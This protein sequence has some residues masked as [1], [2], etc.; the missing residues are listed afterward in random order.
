VF[1]GDYPKKVPK[2]LFVRYF[3]LSE[4]N[5]LILIH[6]SAQNKCYFNTVE[7]FC[8]ENMRNWKKSGHEKCL[9]LVP[10]NLMLLLTINN[11]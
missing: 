4:I 5:H 6:K 8:P 3:K 10:V 1:D 9:S 11:R 7:N 2:R